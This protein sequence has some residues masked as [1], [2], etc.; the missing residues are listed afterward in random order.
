MEGKGL[1]KHKSFKKKNKLEFAAQHKQEPG[2]LLK[3]EMARLKGQVRKIIL[4]T[5][6]QMDCREKKRLARQMCQDRRRLQC[7]HVAWS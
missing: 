7:R 3:E 4:A 5:T 6:L 1:E 2:E